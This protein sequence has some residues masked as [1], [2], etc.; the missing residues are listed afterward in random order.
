VVYASLFLSEM[1]RI[2]KTDDLPQCCRLWLSRDP[3][4]EY[5]GIN[6][7]EYCGN[8]PANAFDPLGLDCAQDYLN[9]TYGSWTTK[10]IIN[11]FGLL[12]YLPSSGNLAHILEA[13]AEALAVKGGV[14]VGLG[15][16]GNYLLSRG[17]TIMF[18]PASNFGRYGGLAARAA[19]SESSMAAGAGLRVAAGV[20]AEGLA[21]AGAGLTAFATTAQVIAAAHCHN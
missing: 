1:V 2:R 19:A 7:Y 11:N 20:G 12:S 21:V 10:N 4:G 9:Q 5:A 8:D 16:A 13:D 17:A 15:A 14:V 6:L 18:Q 3:L